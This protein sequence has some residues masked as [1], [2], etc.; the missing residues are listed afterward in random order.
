MEN[1]AGRRPR[2]FI[3]IGLPRSGKT[4]WRNK[5][6]KGLVISADDIRYKVYGQRFFGEGEHLMWAIR[7]ILL[8]TAL[9]QKLDGIVIDETNTT[10]KRRA[11]IIKKAKE[12]GYEIIAVWIKTSPEECIKRA[13][14][15]NDENIIPV[16]KR[17]AEQLEVPWQGEGFDG[18]SYKP[19]DLMPILNSITL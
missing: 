8:N 13:E 16:I 5:N 3:L 14:L 15:E 7:G 9:E 11:P 6:A 10:Q 4:T 18:I 19:E 2:I 1:G 12:W 17:M